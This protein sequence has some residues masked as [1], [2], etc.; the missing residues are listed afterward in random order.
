MYAMT[1]CCGSAG[2]TATDG[3]CC[4]SGPVVMAR[5]APTDSSR[6][7]TPGP[8][9]SRPSV[10]RMRC[11][12]GSSQGRYR[13]PRRFR[14]GPVG[15]RRAGVRSRTGLNIARL[16]LKKTL[17]FPGID[18]NPRHH[19]PLISPMPLSPIPNTTKKKNP[20]HARFA[21]RGHHSQD[22]PAHPIPSRKVFLKDERSASPYQ[23]HIFILFCS[24]LSDHSKSLNLHSPYRPKPSEAV[25]RC[26][27]F[28]I[29]EA[30]GAC[31]EGVARRRGLPPGMGHTLRRDPGVAGLR[32]VP[33]QGL[34]L[35]RL[36][37]SG[38]DRSH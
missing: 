26:H 2:S 13:R 4:T 33:G 38:R 36:C 20:D 24:L 16:S 21:R 28:V 9:A 34:E 8:L 5:L 14:R 6:D 18:A 7:G 35:H 25:T 30:T 12:Q 22:H 11:S 17:T 19:S 31:V 1:T 3:I 29:R 10:S 15:C 32:G 37:K 23:V 27:L